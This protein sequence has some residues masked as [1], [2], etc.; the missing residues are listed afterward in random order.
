M[1][2]VEGAILALIGLAIGAAALVYLRA[3]SRALYR[4][5]ARVFRDFASARGLVFRDLD[6]A[7]RAGGAM[8]SVEVHVH[9]EL[10]RGKYA[11]ARYSARPMVPMP[12]VVVL[13]RAEAR[14]PEGLAELA[15]GDLAFDA[16]LVAYGGDDPVTRAAISASA[17]AE[18]LAL[19]SPACSVSRLELGPND[20]LLELVA[21]ADEVF[22]ERWL[23]AS[24]DL[25]TSFATG[26][27][28]S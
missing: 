18:L 22:T 15:T 2:P 28:R 13:R 5:R 19:V 10:S 11:T 25:V 9:V 24:L 4:A 23:A 3:R 6:G 8:R 17:R 14:P 12:R 7:F 16:E 27:R 20:V 26:R 21:D 1:P